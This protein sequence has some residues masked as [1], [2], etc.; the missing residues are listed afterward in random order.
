MKHISIYLSQVLKSREEHLKAIQRVLREEHLKEFFGEPLSVPYLN[1][2]E[3]PLMVV[4][5]T[6]CFMGVDL[7][8]IGIPMIVNIIPFDYLRNLLS[9]HAIIL[10]R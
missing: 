6:I 7:N 10:C 2:P 3:E 8:N 4:R 9:I 1:Y 5:R